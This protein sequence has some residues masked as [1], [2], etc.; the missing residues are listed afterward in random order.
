MA[1]KLYLYTL[2]LSNNSA[3]LNLLGLNGITVNVSLLRRGILS[4]EL[5]KIQEIATMERM[6]LALKMIWNTSKLAAMMERA[7]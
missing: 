1:T 7:L 3:Q 6:T 5:E 4:A 2:N